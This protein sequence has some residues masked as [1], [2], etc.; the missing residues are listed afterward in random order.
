[1][2]AANF[3]SLILSWYHQN[4]RALPWRD[5][6]DPYRIWLSEIILQQ[7]RVAQGLPYYLEF[8]K[9]FPTLSDLAAAEEERVLRIWQGLGYYSRARNMHKCAR[10]LVDEHAG[11]FP[12]TFEGLLKLPGIGRYT[13][14]AIASFAFN[15][16][17]PTI[18]GNVYRLLSRVYGLEVDISQPT[19]FKIFF[20][21]AEDL[22]DKKDPGDFN[23][24]MMELGAT[25]C[26]PR[27]PNCSACVL[28]DQCEA[29]ALN[30]QN[31]L[32]VKSKKIKKS[33][34][35]FNYLIIRLGKNIGMS[36]RAAGDIWQG[37]NEFYLIETPQPASWETLES[38]L[39]DQLKEHEMMITVHEES[40]KHG[41]THQTLF[42]N[43]F[44]IEIKD[45]PENR[46]ILILNGLTLYNMTEIEQLAKP[47]LINNFLNRLSISVDL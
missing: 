23:Q 25:V 13:A 37:L 31:Q 11:I 5:T 28:K 4:K 6:K 44:E 19:S 42:S 39:L 22:I 7:T 38:D 15:V 30:K 34:R 17:V 43:F 3:S 33:T 10:L 8:V 36:A 1:M 20:E 35:Y 41:L 27:Q 16:A 32:P 18:D 14:A 40:L 21:L 29:N 9:E 46:N 45:T 12:G 24:S 26:S 47:V 2:S